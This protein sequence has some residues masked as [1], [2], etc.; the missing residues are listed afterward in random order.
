ML[1]ACGAGYALTHATADHDWSM[2]ELAHEH[3][4]RRSRRA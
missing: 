1:A 2:F 3:I 4:R